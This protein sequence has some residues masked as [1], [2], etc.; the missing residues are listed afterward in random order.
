M[1]R[2]WGK[3]IVALQGRCGNTSP[4]RG[5]GRGWY[6]NPGSVCFAFEAS[7]IIWSMLAFA[8][9]VS[10]KPGYISTHSSGEQDGSGEALRVSH[11]AC[12][13]H[14]VAAVQVSRLSPRFLSPVYLSYLDLYLLQT[15]LLRSTSA[16]KYSASRHNLGPACNGPRSR[17]GTPGGGQKPDSRERWP[18]GYIPA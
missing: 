4:A 1:R 12:W 9:I 15:P 5:C 17:H 2:I 18:P 8:Q 6:Y 7:L 11:F 3:G 10:K 13:M 14:Q 16:R